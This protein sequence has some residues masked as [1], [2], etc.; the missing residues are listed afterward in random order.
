MK[1]PRP[2]KL[3]RRLWAMQL[4]LA[5]GLALLFTAALLWGLRG[6][7]PARAEPDTRYVDGHTGG[8][9]S[10]CTNPADPCATI[11]HALSQAANGDEIR[12]AEG[13]YTET[14]D[15][16]GTTVTLKGGYEAAGWT[17]DI[18]AHPTIV[19]ADGANDSVISI[20]PYVEVTIEGFTVQGAN[21]TGVD[22]FGGIS[23]DRAMVIVSGTI[24]QNNQAQANGGGIYIQDDGESASLALIN[25]SVLNNRADEGGGINASGWPTVTLKSVEIKGNTAQ[26]SGGGINAGYVSITDSH[27]ISNTAGSTGGGIHTSVAYIYNSE[28]S[29]NEANG[30]GDIGGGGIAVSN[31]RLHLQDSVVSNNRAVGTVHN[32]PSGIAAGNADV[33]IINTRI[34]DN[35]IGTLAVALWSSSFTITNSLV[36]NN[37]G[38]GIG[39]DENPVTGTLMNTTIAGNGGNGIRLTGSDV[40]I[41][42]SIL[43]GN[44]FDNNCGG[45]CTITYSDVGTGDTAGTDNI[46][47]DPKFVDAANGDYHLG[48]G[49]P[50]IDKGTRAGAPGVDIEGTPR[51]AAPDMGAYEWMG[52]RIFLPLTLSDFGQ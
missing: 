9:D 8:D 33:S 51:D 36:V 16:V 7:T 30:V 6:V 29:G 38:A 46:S 52:F 15:I 20:S 28:I 39:A 4:G 47:A 45:N 3:D 14:L 31:V 49:S 40:R 2:T 18:S 34:S 17:R 48:V 50:C 37:D 12:V 23:I 5:A 41:T 13:T 35:K 10:D 27:I 44:A 26:G 11:G 25:S 42:N 32:G 24:V 21:H 43:W 1:Y 19:D 22:S